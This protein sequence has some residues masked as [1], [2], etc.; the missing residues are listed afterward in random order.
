[1]R[2]V[3]EALHFGGFIIIDGWGGDCQIVGVWFSVFRY[4]YFVFKSNNP[5]IFFAGLF[6]YALFCGGS[7]SHRHRLK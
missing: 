3:V 6:E 1:M 4:Q 5:A 7:F 2:I